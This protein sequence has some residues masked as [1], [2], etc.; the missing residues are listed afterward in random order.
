MIGKTVLCTQHS[1]SQAID[2]IQ[3]KLGWIYESSVM[4]Y[5]FQIV[6]RLW[7]ITPQEP[8]TFRQYH[9]LGNEKLFEM[10]DNAL[11]RRPQL[12]KLAHFFGVK[13]SINE[14]SH[15]LL[16]HVSILIMNFV[17]D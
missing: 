1:F 8:G 11:S 2:A 3:A 10:F 7:D 12:Q 4:T 15:I 16:F 5:I 9:R 13:V 17:E 6:P 14:N